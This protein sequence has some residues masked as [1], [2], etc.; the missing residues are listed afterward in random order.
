MN[1]RGYY[2]FLSYAPVVPQTTGPGSDKWVRTF[3]TDLAKAVQTK[4]GDT[5][6]AMAP[7]FY[8]GVVRPGA[9]L[10]IESSI[11]LGMSHVFVPLYSPNYLLRQWSVGQRETFQSRLPPSGGPNIL[12]V[13][14]TPISGPEVP[15][16]LDVAL[17]WGG[18]IEPYL[19]LGL[20]AMCRLKPYWTQYL[21][22]VDRLAG[23]IKQVAEDAP[24]PVSTLQLTVRQPDSIAENSFVIAVLAP[25][26]SGAPNGRSGYGE[27]GSQWSPYLD[28]Q[29]VG[30]YLNDFATQ[31]GFPSR[32]ADLSDDRS[33]LREARLALVDPWI[34]A[35]P[36]GRRVLS[37]AIQLLPS[38]AVVLLVYDVRD[39][40][41]AAQGSEYVRQVDELIQRLRGGR[42]RR[43][44]N[45]SEFVDE[46]PKATVI[47]W[48]NHLKAGKVYPPTGPS[49]MGRP[50]LG[51]PP[52]ARRNP[53]DAPAE[54]GPPAEEPPH[55]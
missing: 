6:S 43:A 40:A 53:P 39:P 3:F 32:M 22:L 54:P 12:P 1:D 37:E 5:N 2:F 16:D 50:R 27:Q 19:L 17:R 55:D 46:G 11:A 33:L 14:W 4:V 47:A 52:P 13:N 25:D 10:R 45:L 42:P 31:L 9:D 18:D 48:R 29:P 51:G 23:L 38:W 20:Q 35:G 36:D 34:L 26:Q 28:S 21:L 44:C 8:D 15:D 24:L 30:A 49:T 7:G 41:H